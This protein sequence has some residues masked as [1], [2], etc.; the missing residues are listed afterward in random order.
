MGTKAEV[1][2]ILM[3]EGNVIHVFGWKSFPFLEILVF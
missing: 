1:G 2:G 3:C